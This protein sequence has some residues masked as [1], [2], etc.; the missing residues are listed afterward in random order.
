MNYTN[1]QKVTYNHLPSHELREHLTTYRNELLNYIKEQ[2][3]EAFTTSFRREQCVV[4]YKSPPDN[5][6]RYSVPMN[7]SARMRLL[8]EVQ[9]VDLL[10]DGKL[11]GQVANMVAS[12]RLPQPPC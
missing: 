6:L 4:S 1:D 8:K 3:I 11:S 10:L 2:K 12:I 5:I 9:R 7:N